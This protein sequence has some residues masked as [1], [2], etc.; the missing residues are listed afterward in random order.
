MGSTFNPQ[1]L[2]EKLAKLNSSQQSIETLSH[3]CIFHMNKAKLVVE[4]WDR[5]FHCSPREQR[6]AFLYLANDILQNSRRKGSEFVGEFWKVLSEAL[7]DVIE[8]GDENE[9]R[10]ARR[11]VVIWEDRKVFGSRGQLLKEEFVERQPENGTRNGKQFGIKL[12][13]S[14]GNTLEKL[15][16]DYQV[17][18]GGELDE[19]AIL[20][21]CRNAISS[22]EKIDKEIGCDTS[23]E[24]INGSGFVED[25]QGQHVILRDCIEQ[26]LV[27]EA[28]RASLVANMREAL[29]EQEVKLDQVRNQLQAARSQSEQAGNICQQFV[30]CNNVELIAEQNLKE[31]HTAKVPNSF[32]PREEQSAPVMYTRQL[33]FSEKSAHI[34][35]DPRKSAAAAV[36]AKLS[37]STSSAQMLSYVL[38]SLA[39]EGVIVNPLKDSPGDYPSEKRPK[40]ETEQSSYKVPPSSQPPVPPFPHPDSLHH[41]ITSTTQQLTSNEQPPPPSSPP[42][43]PPPLPPM[44]PYPLPQFIQTAGSMSSVPYNY[45][46]TQQQQQASMPGYPSVGAPVTGMSPYTAPPTNPYQVFQ[47]S[48]GGFYTQ[49]SSLPMAPQ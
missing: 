3:W 6:L 8:N 4:T 22:V 42:P 19:D 26:L 37:A 20:N 25:L 40:L 33:P 15:V 46:M 11:L 34:E 43:M 49:P 13:Q 45:G 18:Y 44:Q 38:S 1:I 7:R 35:E 23:S 16:S 27:V 5:Q 29:Q 39:S 47:G 21:K 24:Q 17:L 36:A 14:A 30:K 9:Q 48:E 31:A 32:M 2:M 10:A 41:N 28:S 12:K